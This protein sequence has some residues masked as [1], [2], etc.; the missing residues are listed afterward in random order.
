M[1]RDRNKID[2]VYDY[3]NREMGVDKHKIQGKVRKRDI[4]DARRLFWYVMR[5]YFE[6]SFQKVANLT[7]HNHATVIAACK[8][9]D[10][11][12]DIYPKITTT[13]YKDICFQLDVMKDSL[14]E[15]VAELKQKMVVIN[16]ELNK[17]LT[18]KQLQDER[19]KL[20]C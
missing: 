3:I 18:I 14:E 7:N 6:Y 1:E 17:I 19:K 12:A 2:F 10:M 16:Q 5:N 11:Y 15:Q 9:F 8:K 13:P 20:H 4:N